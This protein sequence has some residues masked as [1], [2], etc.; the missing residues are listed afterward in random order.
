MTAHHGHERRRRLSLNYAGVKPADDRHG[1]EAEEAD[2]ETR[3]RSPSEIGRVLTEW[4]FAFLTHIPQGQHTTSQHQDI[5][6]IAEGAMG[7][8]VGETGIEHG[9]QRPRYRLIHLRQWYATRSQHVRA[10]RVPYNLHHVATRSRTY[11]HR[12]VQ[13]LSIRPPVPR[14]VI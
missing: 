13:T 14:E 3:A 12:D 5:A 4:I 2:H 7:E 11:A 6:E 1:K 8:Q 10:E 9:T